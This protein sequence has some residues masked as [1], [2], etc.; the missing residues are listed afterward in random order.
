MIRRS[1]AS[2]ARRSGSLAHSLG[3]LTLHVE[4]WR[5][6]YPFARPPAS[7]RIAVALHPS[8]GNQRQR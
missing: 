8:E 6:V 4:G 3:E 1:L 5:A 7:L 2:L